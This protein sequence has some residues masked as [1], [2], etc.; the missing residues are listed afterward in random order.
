MTKR[1]HFFVTVKNICTLLA[2]VLFVNFSASGQLTGVKTIGGTSPDYATFTL[3]ITDLNTAGVGTGGVIFHVAA[4]ETFNENPPEIIATGTVA[5][6]IVFQKNGVGANPVVKPL[7]AG[8]LTTTSIGANADA[9]IIINGGD[10]ITFDGIDIDGNSAFDVLLAKYEYGYYLKK[11]SGTDA[12]KNVTIKNCNVTMYHNVAPI[13]TIGSGIFISNISGTA[14]VSVTST[15]G[16]SENIK[17]YSNTITGASVAIQARGFLALTPFDFYD[18]NIEIGVDGANTI[19]FGTNTG[20]GYGIYTIYQNNLKVNNNIV[21]GTGTSIVYGIYN[22][23]GTSTNVEM[24]GNTVTVTGGGTTSSLYGIYNLGGSTALGNTVTMS[25]NT[26]TNCTYPTA[27]SAIIYLLYNAGTAANVVMTGNTVSNNVFPTTGSMYGIYSTSCTELTMTN[28][29]VTNN[30]RLGASGTWYL[31]YASTAIVTYHSNVISNNSVPNTSGTA[32]AVIYA[33][34]NLG[35]PTVE[36]IYDN[37]IFNLSI[38]GETTSAACAIYGM[39]SNTTATAVKNIYNNSIY[40]LSIANTSTGGG[41]IYGINQLLGADVRIYKNNLYNFS[42]AGANGIVY[43]LSVASGTV[44]LYNNYVSDLKAPFSAGLNAVS[45]IYISGGT[46]VGAYYNTVYLNALSASATTFGTSGIYV[47][48]TPTVELRNNIIV[49]NSV[50]GPTG[51]FTTAHRR[52]STTI[53]TYAATS[54]N[55]DF[56]AGTPGA[57]NLIYYDGTNEDQTL[58]DYKARVSPI[59]GA[60]FTENPPFLNVT[61]T[62]YNLHIDSTIATQIESGGSPVTTPIAI[63]DDFDG[64]TRHASTPDV[65]ADEFNGIGADFTAPLISYTPLLSSTTTTARTLTTNI[66]DPS[67]VPTTGTGLP[68]LYWNVNGGTYTGVQAV[69]VSGSEY[70]FTFGG[71]VTNDIIGY[72]IVAQDMNNNVGAFP[73]GGAG[74]FTA[75]PP[76]AATPPTNPSTYIIADIPLG[77]DYTVGLTMFNQI[78]GKNIYFVQQTSK[79]TRDIMVEVPDEQLP[80]VK[81]GEVQ[82]SATETGY[83]VPGI[84]QSVQLD[85]VKWV[86]MENGQLYNGELYIKKFESPQYSYPDGIDGIYAS[87][88]AAVNDLNIRGVSAATR[89]LLTDAAYTTETFPLVVNIQNASNP[90]PTSTNTV[91]FKPAA[92]IN[93]VVSGA[94]PAGQIF[95]ILNSYVSIDG[96]NSAAATR[97]LTL[98]NT[99]TVSPQVVVF[100]STGTTPIVGNSIKN[101]IIINGAQTSSALI[102]SDGTAPGTAGYFNDI[103]IQNNSIQKAYIAN[104][105]NAVIAAGN[106][107]GLLISGNDF[108]EAGTNSV[109][110]VAI[111]VQGVDGATVVDNN[112]GNFLSTFAELNRGVW[113]ATGTRNSMIKNNTVTNQVT[114]ATGAGAPIGFSVSAAV[115]DANIIIEDNIISGLV[116]AGT[117]T[118]SGIYVFSTTS[119]VVVQRNSISNVKNTNTGGYGSNGLYF[120]STLNPANIEAINNI[121]WDI[122]GNGYTGSAVGDNGY[123][124]IITSGAGYKIYYNSVHLNTNQVTATNLSAAINITS[125]VTAAGAIDLRDNVFASSQTVGANQYAIY[126][127]AAAAV[128]SNINYNDYFTLGPNLGYLTAAQVDLAAWRVATSQDLN[129]ISGNPQFVAPEDLRPVAGS[130]VISAGTPITGIT[131]D[132]LGVTRNATMPS[133]GA[134][135]EGVQTALT[136][137]E[138]TSAI[139]DTFHCVLQWTDNSNNELGFKIERR[140]DTLSV[141]PWVL[142]DSVGENQTTFTNYGLDPDTRYSYRIYAYNAMGISPYSNEVFVT[143]IIPVELIAFTAN[144][145]GTSVLVNWT[146]ATELNNKGFEVERL[147]DAQKGWETLTFISGKGTTTEE[148]NYSFSD[149]YKFMAVTG[150]VSYRLK[151]ID[152]DG[153]YYYSNAAEVE[154]DFSP[155]EYTL[156]QNYPNPFNPSTTI[157]YAIPF[158]SNVKIVVYNMLGESISEILNAVQETG[159]YDVTWNASN[160]ASGI[161]FYTIEAKSA[162]GKNSFNSVK[163]MMLVK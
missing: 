7:A 139:A 38:G 130:P 59:D 117:G 64:N 55:N 62:P 143:T 72:Y 146:T 50:A 33:Y 145:V 162:D 86:A 161:Y 96:S 75:N 116:T 69:Y 45:G 17:V 111:Y 153:R 80:A 49:N 14:S 65:G 159:Y 60:S 66:S 22:G 112:I 78:T 18:H 151:Q 3:A 8:T 93:A 163:K 98:E 101:T 157:K 110:L 48:T 104:Y 135:E 150:T 68:M 67:G 36:H 115:P 113:F 84:M 46:A 131:T 6:P 122:A 136:A 32:S 24:T 149:D 94:S 120:A 147:L 52:T 34:Y 76:A 25:N 121:I 123:G 92:G 61:T 39:H 119:G 37:Q 134:F 41:T 88:S 137:P 133:I 138:I 87:I 31:T 70:T 132:Y 44:A 57:A 29:T 51:G 4:G 30:Q 56:Y 89:F 83:H 5:N 158:T 79:P 91:T 13:V 118:A 21:T 10:Y 58:S 140:L 28:N 100:G 2:F 126:S 108:T 54:N 19:N 40:N 152:Y 74:G 82:N 127:G 85:E 105:N 107:T 27:T 1:I 109:R 144:Q 16:R 148:Q 73:A 97:N 77:G 42:A 63:T 47:S 53:G 43:G 124:I 15:D 90:Y 12:S 142:I 9:V 20:T 129:S 102:V 26:V 160:K 154:V 95:K 106:G 11:A 156:F 114:T 128:Y 103:T 155:K 141:N 81:G 35:S 23:T 99:S 125:G 71:G